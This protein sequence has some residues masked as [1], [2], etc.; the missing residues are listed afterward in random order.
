MAV[1]A[2]ARKMMLVKSIMIVNLLMVVSEE[3]KDGL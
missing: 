1:A 2:K 3:E